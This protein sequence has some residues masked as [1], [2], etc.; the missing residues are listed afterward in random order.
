MKLTWVSTSAMKEE[1]ERRGRNGDTFVL[2]EWGGTAVR[3]TNYPYA[4][5]FHFQFKFFGMSLT[6]EIT[7]GKTDMIM[8]SDWLN[9]KIRKDTQL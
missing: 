5:S 1:L 4:F 8:L 7:V 9:D 3:V 6:K 2:S